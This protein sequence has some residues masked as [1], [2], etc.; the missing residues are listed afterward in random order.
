[1]GLRLD[2]SIEAHS[3]AFE[4]ENTLYSWYKVLMP[5]SYDW[6]YESYHQF[7]S[8]NLCEENQYCKNIQNLI[9]THTC[10][11]IMK[12]TATMVIGVFA[13]VQSSTA[14]VIPNN[15]AHRPINNQAQVQQSEPSGKYISQHLDY[16]KQPT[17]RSVKYT[18]GDPNSWKGQA[19]EA[20][21]QNDQ[22]RK[23]AEESLRRLEDQR[24]AAL[25]QSKKNFQQTDQQ[26]K[27]LWS[28]ASGGAAAAAGAANTI[29]DLQATMQQ[30]QMLDAQMRREKMNRKAK[31]SATVSIRVARGFNAWNQCVRRLI[32][33]RAKYCGY[34]V[35][36]KSFVN[37][38]EFS[39][40]IWFLFAWGYIRVDIGEFPQ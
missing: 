18:T 15:N 22:E 23:K 21:A 16:S 37:W 3:E 7:T 26:S 9:L 30:K 8:S 31:D 6:M 24:Q 35:Q 20:L 27:N 28:R 14:F 36:K 29:S 11:I 4:V 39:K 13:L 25:D 19:G 33:Q 40:V 1:M 2:A 10:T 5:Q 17:I 34:G 12:V 32:T 38:F